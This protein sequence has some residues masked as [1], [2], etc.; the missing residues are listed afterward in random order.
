MQVTDISLSMLSDTGHR[1][2]GHRE[3]CN[4]SYFLRS[5]LFCIY[6]SKCM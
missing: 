1:N 5:A 6:F 4:Y 3:L 2:Y